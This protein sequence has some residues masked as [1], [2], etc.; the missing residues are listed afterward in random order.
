MTARRFCATCATAPSI[1]GGHV[2]APCA[3]RIREL[4]ALA[5]AAPTL[6]P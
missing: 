5:H 2:C 1:P 3:A 6:R 4:V